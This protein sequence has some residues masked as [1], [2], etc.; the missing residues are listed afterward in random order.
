MRTVLSFL[1]RFHR[2]SALYVTLAVSHNTYTRTEY[3]LFPAVYFHVTSPLTASALRKER[4]TLRG[5]IA[6][7]TV[8][9]TRRPDKWALE[10]STTGSRRSSYRK[11]R[12]LKAKKEKRKKRRSAHARAHGTNR[13]FYGGKY[14]SRDFNY[15]PTNVECVA[16]LYAKERKISPTIFGKATSRYESSE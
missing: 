8:G 3:I 15:V 14:F 9:K 7:I 12:W 2:P 11:K 4:K 16:M 10:L 5:T 1:P 13:A 6:G